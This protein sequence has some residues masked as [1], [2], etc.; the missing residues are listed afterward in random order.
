MPLGIIGVRQEGGDPLLQCQ[1]H[2]RDSPFTLT[3]PTGCVPLP[4]LHAHAIVFCPSLFVAT[5]AAANQGLWPDGLLDKLRAQRLPLAF[6]H[7]Y[8]HNLKSC[9]SPFAPA[10]ST[11]HPPPNACRVSCCHGWAGLW[12]LL[13]ATTLPGFPKGMTQTLYPAQW[14]TCYPQNLITTVFSSVGGVQCVS[15]GLVV[16]A[17]GMAG[18]GMG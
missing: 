17:G 13:T 2:Q 6:N 7:M 15:Q 12:E 18:E 5:P 10:A 14:L 8:A 16:G 4:L 3:L 11:F 1:S 9:L